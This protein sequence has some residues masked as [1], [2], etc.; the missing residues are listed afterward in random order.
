MV[1]AERNVE[2]FDGRIR[3]SAR[4]IE[5]R[6]EGFNKGKEGHSCGRVVTS[7][8]HNRYNDRYSFGWAK[9][10]VRNSGSQRNQ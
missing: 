4:Y 3:D 2:K 1:S 8:S 7:H 10:I 6:V 5:G 9:S